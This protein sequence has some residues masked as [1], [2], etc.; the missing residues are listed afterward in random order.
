MYHML[1][2]ML[3]LQEGTTDLERDWLPVQPLANLNV[4]KII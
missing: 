4:D 2:L 3:N 1:Y